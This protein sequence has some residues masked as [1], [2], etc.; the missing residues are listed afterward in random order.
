MKRPNAATALAASVVLEGRS[1]S[2]T[3]ASPAVKNGSAASIVKALATLVFWIAAGNKMIVAQE[4]SETFG[5]FV[6]ELGQS[7]LSLIGLA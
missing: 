1:L 4:Q 3:Q 5:Q 6:T 7:P 2:Q